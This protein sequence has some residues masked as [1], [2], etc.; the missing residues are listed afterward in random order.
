MVFAQ[1]EEPGEAEST[2]QEPQVETEAL[3]P[4]EKAPQIPQVLVEGESEVE[5]RTVLLEDLRKGFPQDLPF[6]GFQFMGQPEKKPEAWKS[7][8]IA[9]FYEIGADD[10]IL[11]SAWGSFN[12]DL[13]FVVNKQGYVTLPGE[14][15]VYVIGL[16]FG[17]LEKL[18]LDE[19]RKTYAEALAPEKLKSGEVLFRV[20]LGKV[21]GTQ[22]MITGQVGAPGGYT[23]EQPLVLLMN[24][25][26]I[27]GGISAEGSLRSI[28]VKRGETSTQIDLYDLLLHGKID[29]ED[30]LLRTGDVVSVP[31]R[32][33]TVSI[34]GSIK[35]SAIYEL[36]AQ[37]NLANLIQMAGGFTASADRKRTQ[38]KRV[39]P[40]KGYMLI[41]VD[42]M[43]KRAVDVELR[44]GDQIEVKELGT[45]IRGAIVIIEGAG[46]VHP[47][48]YE[49]SEENE[50]LI[51]FLNQVE[52]Y[53]DAVTDHIILIR[54][55]PELT[56]EKVILNLEEAGA[57]EF[58][59]QAEDQLFVI[60]KH[61]LK[62]GE[63]QVS[64]KGHVKT[65]G[66][67]QLQENL[68]LSDVLFLY[69]G[70]ADPDFLAQAYLAR[71]DIIRVDKVSGAR[72]YLSFDLGAVLEGEEDHQLESNDEI[73]TYPKGRFG[74]G[75]GGVEIEGEVRYPGGYPLLQDMTLEDLLV[76]AG[77]AT[78]RAYT[79]EVQVNRLAIGKEPPVTSFEVSLSEKDEFLLQAGDKVFVRQIP[80]Y[81]KRPKT[82]QIYG[83]VKFEGG[84]VLTEVN[85]RLSHLVERAGG[86]SQEV[87]LEGATLTRLREEVGEEEKRLQV[88][89]D[90]EKAL[91]GDEKYDLILRGGDIINIPIHDYVINIKGAVMLPK[92][93]QYIPGQKSGYYVDMVGGYLDNA[94]VRASHIMRANGLN[95]KATRR[96]WFD[97]EVPPGSTLVIPEK[98]PAKPLWRNTRTLSLVGGA[99][100]TGLIWNAAN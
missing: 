70:L 53:E 93:V 26:S 13:R 80:F 16:K 9:P 8:S 23:F 22:A 57:K 40:D 7:L 38:I 10:E 64:L 94:D 41:D 73:V 2:G 72:R 18:F 100:V 84:Y 33:R 4:V 67:Y 11:L 62:G 12:L 96:F 25:L 82:V 24:A 90:M 56:S 46:V 68:T 15:R 59:L 49:L 39:D 95:M 55:G 65:P 1:Q 75:Y 37:E 86:L 31:Y 88:V 29:I 78:E 60:S 30:Y 45:S 21:R 76:Q 71:G 5:E 91:S 87:F 74:I 81:S 14:K 3:Q 79:G 44:D 92:L 28:E 6:F 43:V 99:L 35:R 34:R 50:K 61:E 54:V 32:S 97:P 69:G 52:L 36:K 47:G 19:L 89:M 48:T 17:Q 66:I 63:K 20:T 98:K 51:T 27:A 77:K 85:E 58:R 83:E 42:L